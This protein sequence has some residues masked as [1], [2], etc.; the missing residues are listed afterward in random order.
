MARGETV[1]IRVHE[2]AGDLARA[3]GAEVHEDQRVAVLHRGIGLTGGADHGR[4]DEL[5]VFTA[6]ISGLQAGDRILG[7]GVAFG[8]G[9]QVIGQLHAIPAVVAVHRVVAADQ[10]GDAPDAQRGEGVTAALQRGFGAARRRVAPVEEG[11]QINGFGAALCSQLD[12]GQDV[13]VVAVHAARRQQAHDMH[14]LAGRYGLIDGGGQHRV[15]EEVAVGDRF[16]QPG[17]ILVHDAAGAQVDVADFRVA[18]LP[19]G[20]ADIQ[21][22]SGDQR[23]RLLAT[24]DP[25]P[26]CRRSGS[27][28]PAALHD[29]RNR[30]GSPVPSVLLLDIALTS[31]ELLSCE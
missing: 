17:Q 31:Y 12:H 8:R 29:G 20:Q 6:L 18:H 28:C 10:R 7:H 30:P 21:P 22:G 3:V 16:V 13:L 15:G 23:M 9:Q 1:E 14:R 4:S 19:I 25:S 26:E 5:V 27:R 24:G 2:G 11:M